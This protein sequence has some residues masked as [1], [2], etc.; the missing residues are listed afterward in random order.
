MH[1]EVREEAMTAKEKAFIDRLL[2][3]DAI[4]YFRLLR[5]I[6]IVAMSV[7]TVIG[8]I[9]SFV[10]PAN[11]LEKKFSIVNFIIA[12]AIALLFLL[13]ITI[14]GKKKFSSKYKADLKHGLKRVIALHI[15]QKQYVELSQTCHFHSNYP[16]LNSIQVD[17]D[18]FNNFQVGDII[19]VEFAKYS[20][21][22]LGYY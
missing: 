7:I 1:Q 9:A 6:F 15:Q 10:N 20:Q 18:D 11:D 19:H 22:Y 2:Q 21:T 16:G 12:S 3:Q 5:L 4:G 13:S 17:P 8:I 14:Y